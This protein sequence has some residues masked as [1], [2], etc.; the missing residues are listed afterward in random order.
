M[1]IIRFDISFSFSVRSQLCEYMCKYF[2]YVR[3][4]LNSKSYSCSNSWSYTINFRRMIYLSSANKLAKDEVRQ[5]TY[6]E[7]IEKTK[8]AI[9]Q[10]VNILLDTGPRKIWSCFANEQPSSS[11]TLYRYTAYWQFFSL[12]LSSQPFH[13]RIT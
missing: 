6:F 5:S 3:T 12:I 1:M 8:F 9:W 7:Q 4:V 13:I 11:L 2:S 10:N